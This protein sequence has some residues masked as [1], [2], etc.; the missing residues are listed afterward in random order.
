M[1]ADWTSDPPFV[2]PTHTGGHVDVVGRTWEGH[3][4]SRLISLKKAHGWHGAMGNDYAY[5]MGQ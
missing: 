4:S 5:R 2:G 1:A 3:S